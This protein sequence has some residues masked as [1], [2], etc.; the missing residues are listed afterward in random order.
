[1]ATLTDPQARAV[2][3][4]APSL[5]IVAGAGSGKTRVLTLRVAR[6]IRDGSADADHTAVCTFTRKA[7]HELRERLAPLRRPGLDP[8]RRTAGCRARACGPARLHQ[9]ALTLLR[10]HAARH[11]PAAAGGGGAPLAHRRPTW[12]VTGRWP[13]RSTPRSAGPKPVACRRTGTPTPPRPPAG[14]WR[15]STPIG[16]PSC[17]RRLQ[18]AA[19]RRRSPRPRRRAGAR[20][21]PPAG[22]AGLRRA[23]CT[24]ATGT[25]RVDEFQ[26]VNPAQFRLIRALLGERGRPVRGGRPQPGHLRL[27]R[28]R[29]DPAGPLPEVVPGH[30]GGA[31]RREPPLTPQVV[32]AATAA[33]GPAT[34]ADPPRSL[35]P[36]GPMPMVTAF[37]DRARG[38]GGGVRSSS[39]VSEDGRPGR[40]R[41]C[42]PGP[43]TSWPVG[44]ALDAGRRPLPHGARARVARAAPVPYRPTGV[45]G[46][47]ARAA[48]AGGGQPVRSDRPPVRGGAERCVELAT[49]HRAK[50]LE[51][52]ARPCRRARGGIRPHRPCHHRRSR[53]TRSG[54]CCTWHSPG[55][56]ASSTARGRGAGPWPT[57][58]PM[59]RRRRRG[60]RIGRH[61]C[62]HGRNRPIRPRT[63]PAVRRPAGQPRTLSGRV[64]R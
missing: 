56:V 37:D 17:L 27:E 55:P 64:R 54:A 41:R 30:G 63:T 36:D 29:P 26:D 47:A 31:P 43:T 52:E 39:T 15:W 23:A 2:E 3:S 10:R 21:R 7:A 48:R 5:C 42:S 45:T 61:A 53:W 62:A 1:M 59:D 8:G 19:G 4:T 51:W 13:R 58:G 40:T 38:R 32:A 28:R 12:W 44:R 16:W 18:P 57:G 6:R 14:R 60:W 34:V 49:F 9:L 50:G 33:P 22:D 25:C 20:R 46:R 11:R 24:G 35:A